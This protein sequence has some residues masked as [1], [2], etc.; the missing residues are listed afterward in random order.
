MKIILSR[1][2][3]DSA[4]GRSPSPIFPDGRMVSLPIPDKRA[5]TRYADIHWFEFN[6]GSLVNELTKG[7][8]PASHFAHLDPDLRY[9]SLP[10]LPHWRPT[11]GQTGAA[12]GHLRNNGVQAGDIFVFFGLFRRVQYVSNKYVWDNGSQPE[13]VI[14][15]WLQVEETITVDTCQR[16]R[17]KWV[18]NHPHF[19][20]G[21][22][23]NNTLYIAREHQTLTN[24][25]PGQIS[26]AGVF[27][28]Y[29]NSLRL[30][31][32]LA[33][34]PNQW[35]LPGWFYP[36]TG[37][38][39]LTYHTDLNR[40]QIDEQGVRLDAVARGQEFV[41]DCQDYP[42]AIEWVTSLIQSP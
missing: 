30:T 37:R 16:D 38:K 20:R 32:S 19:H 27:T 15:G 2:G 14:W 22:E 7:R 40:W 28:F 5:P 24:L 4:A 11:F 6:L 23:A 18:N 29:S 26:G 10:R 3:F 9:D 12:Q 8:V 35:H 17:Y 25:D 39:P 41:L 34:K 13:H 42:E 1:K 36:F 31:A 33:L 21:V